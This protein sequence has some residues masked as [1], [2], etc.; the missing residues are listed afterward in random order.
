MRQPREGTPGPLLRQRPAERVPKTHRR[1]QQQQG[2]AKQ[3]RRRPIAPP[4][5]TGSARKQRANELIGDERGEQGEQIGGADWWKSHGLRK[6][7]NRDMALQIQKITNTGRYSL[8]S[9]SL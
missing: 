7:K 8:G 1:Q 3:L 4:S 6:L 5:G 2:R 9:R